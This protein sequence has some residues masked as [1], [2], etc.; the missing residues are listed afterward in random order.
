MRVLERLFGPMV[1]QSFLKFLSFQI[2][3]TWRDAFRVN[4]KF[5]K[6]LFTMFACSEGKGGELNNQASE[7]VSLAG[8]IMSE[9][10]LLNQS[11][12]WKVFV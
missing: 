4:E 8:N 9:K 3:W 12:N 6:Q 1:Q 2:S 11:D 7:T 10:E 5:I